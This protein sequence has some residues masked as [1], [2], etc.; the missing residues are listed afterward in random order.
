MAVRA[1]ADRRF[2]R[3][4]VKSP[5]RT[6]GWRKLVLPVLRGGLV[7][8]VLLYA[9]DRAVALLTGAPALRIQQ[10]TVHGARHLKPADVLARIRN[11]RGQ[12][13]VRADLDEARHRLLGSPWI[14]EAVLRRVFPSTIEVSIVEREP[15]GIARLRDDLY[16]VAGDGTLLAR[17]GPAHASY[18]LPIIDGLLAAPSAKGLLIEENRAALAARVI[19]GTR[20]ARDLDGLIS[21]IDVSDEDDAV[22][23]LADDPARLHLGDDRFAERLRAYVELAPTLRERVPAIDYVDLRFDTR[24][25]VRPARG[26]AR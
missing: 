26:R 14:R 2:K 6:A 7:L 5:R 25:F 17:Y 13:I 21:Q 10:V 24:V 20:Q 18:D 1:P 3:G 4:R 22:V 8:A 16:L 11:L 15:I 9:A 23:L 12:N 19:A